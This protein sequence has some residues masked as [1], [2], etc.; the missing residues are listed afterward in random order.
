MDSW[1][2]C[3]GYFPFFVVCKRVAV[4]IIFS[5]DFLKKYILIKLYSDIHL[6]IIR[7]CFVQILHDGSKELAQSDSDSSKYVISAENKVWMEH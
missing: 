1:K 3:V 4:C 6:L 5:L 2:R 7:Y